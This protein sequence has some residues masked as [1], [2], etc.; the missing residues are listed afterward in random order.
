MGIQNGIIYGQVV[1]G[2][3]VTTFALGLFGNFIYFIVL[4]AIGVL[5]F[6]FCYFFID[7]LN[8]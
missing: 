7:P 5:A 1:M 3:A 6:F 2:G 8:S 4:S